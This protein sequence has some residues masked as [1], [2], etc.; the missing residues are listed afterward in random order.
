[1]NVEDA[2]AKKTRRSWARIIGWTAL[3]VVFA[4]ICLGAAMAYIGIS[5][6][7]QAEENLHSTIFVIRLVE[8]F[9]AE[10]KRWPRSWEE[11]ESLP[12][13]SDAPRPGNGQLSVIRI[14]GQHGYE[15]PATSKDL[16][17]RVSIDFDADQEKVAGQ[18]PMNFSAIKPIGPYYEYRDYGFVQS[19]Q[20]AIRHVT[21]GQPTPVAE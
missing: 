17:R 4:A 10:Q 1:M 9:V 3:A 2:P 18:D 14:G 12:F 6:S 16:Q 7:L 8:Q 13:S 15:W 19:L 21:Q 11:L 20:E 5:T